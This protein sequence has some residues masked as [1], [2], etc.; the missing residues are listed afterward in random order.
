MINTLLET[1]PKDSGGGGGKTREELVQDKAK[2]I[3]S[4]LPPDYNLAEVRETIK[5]KL[6]G[7]KNLTDKGMNVPLNVFLF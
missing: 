3:L 4:K 2:E 6:P 1:R 5:T 7:P